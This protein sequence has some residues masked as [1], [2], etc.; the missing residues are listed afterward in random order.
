MKL[1]NKQLNSVEELLREKQQ[2]KAELRKADAEG[3]FSL[4][5]IIPAT[6]NKENKGE[7]SGEV[8]IAGLATG[9]LSSL[10]NKD[11]LLAIGLPLLKAAGSQLEKGLVK[12]ILK[13]VG[14][15]YAKWKAIELAFKG[16]KYLIDK[17]VQERAKNR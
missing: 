9:L 1:Y 11:S 4:D 5:D 16:A 3:L 14:F 8:D 6:G 12:K 17:K 2:L 10:G 15:G 7:T 13:E